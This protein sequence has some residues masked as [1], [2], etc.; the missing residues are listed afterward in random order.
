MAVLEKVMQMKQQGIPESQIVDSLKQEGTSPVEINEALSQSK[1]K[2]ALNTEQASEQVIPG[3]PSN[4]NLGNQPTTPPTSPQSS[5]Q[6]SMMAQPA[7]PQASISAQPPTP[8]SPEMQPSQM[9]TQAPSAEMQ[10]S[11][12]QTQTPSQIPAPSE[13]PSYEDQPLQYD[14]PEYQAPEYSDIE[15]INDIAEQIVEEKISKIRNQVSTATKFKEQSNLEIQQIKERLT[16]L[17][18]NFSEL[19]MAILKKIGQYGEDIQNISKEMQTT[20]TSFAKVIDPLA[21]NI[22]ELQKITNSE[23]TQNSNEPKT[24]GRSKKQKEDFENYLR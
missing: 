9:Q 21:S 19:Q 11:P 16:K 2:N 24:K 4:I 8:P 1:I 5:M 13:Y 12:T 3:T 22:K 10:P 6:P 20:Q 18:N 7:E 17:E 14:Y 15:T 23:S